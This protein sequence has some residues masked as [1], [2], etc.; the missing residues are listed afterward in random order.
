MATTINATSAGLSVSPDVSGQ[1]QFQSGGT[2][3]ATVTPTGI[4]TQV[5][6]PAFSITNNG[7]AQ[8]VSTATWTKVALN[9]K[10][11]DTKD[12]KST[13]LNSSHT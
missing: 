10:E 9:T 6:A 3:I 5:G 4:T 2:T 13:R 1:I 7:T 11:F 12:R 8:S